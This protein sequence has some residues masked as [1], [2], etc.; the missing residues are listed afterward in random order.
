MIPPRPWYVVPHGALTCA[1]VADNDDDPDSDTG[2]R[3]VAD[4][5]STNVAELIV[6]LVNAAPEI[7]AALEKAI[8]DI[9]DGG[10][11]RRDI[12][13]NLRAALAKVRP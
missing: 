11:W 9:Q 3:V 4:P 8:N 6:R 10:V 1:I 12:V 7:A 5:L 2:W 13:D